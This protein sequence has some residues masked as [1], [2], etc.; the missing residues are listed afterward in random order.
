MKKVTLISVITASVLFGAGAD[1]TAKNSATGGGSTQIVRL[2][3]VEINSVGDNISDSGI[4]EGFLDKQ[5]S[6]G[7]LSNKTVR[8]TPYSIQTI[9]KEVLDNQGIQNF[10]ELVKYFPSA[11]IEY[12][13]GGEMGRPQTRGFQGSVVGNVFW[14]GFYSV[15]TTAMP[16]A[17]FE[18]LQV[19]NGLAG[20]LYGGQNPAGIFS[21]TRKRPQKDY[22]SIKAEYMSDEYLGTTADVSDKFEKVGYRVTGLYGD[23]EREPND[24]NTRRRMLATALDFYLTDDLTIETNYSY[25]NHIYRGYYN[26]ASI[27]RDGSVPS[28]DSVGVAGSNDERFMR[29]RTA[30]GKFKWTPQDWLY[31]EGGYQWQ[32]AIRS[33]DGTSRFTVP[34]A[35]LKALMQFDTAGVQHNFGIQGNGYDWKNGKAK[36][37]MSKMRNISIADDIKFN[38]NWNIILSAGNSWFKSS[39]YDEDGISWAGSVIYSFTPEIN[40]YFTYA[41]SLQ[42]GEVKTYDSDNGFNATHPL[43]G[44][45]T[46]FEPY[47]SKQYEIGAKAKLWDTLDLSAALFQIT[48]P[49]AVSYSGTSTTVGRKTTYNDDGEFIQLG[50][51]RNRGLELMAGGEIIDGL[52]V[53]G[54]VTFLKTKIHETPYSQIANKSVAGQ[55]KVQANMLIDYTVPFINKLSF[56]TNL[57]YTGTRYANAN[58]TVKIPNYFTLDLGA[59]YSVKHVVGDELIVRFSVS[60]LFDKDYWA[61]VGTIST[62]DTT[63]GSTSASLWRGYG[64]TFMLSAEVKF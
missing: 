57:H 55:P 53:N 32:E 39:T 19:Q 50:E 20:S 56:N 21:Y 49:V 13:G 9:T 63:S 8:D 28:V 16:M 35:F 45:S 61:G 6:S 40:M 26:S 10:D 15:S 34:S 25:Y 1:G 27:G 17:M 2:E 51:Q 46:I 43:Y 29:T 37:T 14:D 59:R 47:R 12:R 58:N 24:S 23:G 3:T 4:S 52:A 36:T 7:P 30:S 18:S 5:V 38:D 41:D 11:Q 54:G 44:Q 22:R 42:S 33:R 31:L 48:R 64:R 62:F 60:N